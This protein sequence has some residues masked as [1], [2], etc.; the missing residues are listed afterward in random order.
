MLTREE[1]VNS[2]IQVPLV[3]LAKSD[4]EQHNMNYVY[5][6]CD[7]NEQDE[8]KEQHGSAG[9]H[10]EQLKA[11]MPYH[12]QI[13]DEVQ[14]LVAEQLRG[15]LRIDTTDDALRRDVANLSKSPFTDK[16]DKT[17]PP[18]KFNPPHFTLFRE[19]EDPDM[20]LMH[21]RNAMTLYANNDALMCTIFATMLQG[22]FVL[23]LDQKEV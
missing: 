1:H 19:D 22:I 8:R 12:A 23:P 15:F 6:N 9:Q 17:E 11:P 3:A 21:Y 10:R 18:R 4:D 2:P 13:Q 20:H 5:S 16:I 14:R 7:T